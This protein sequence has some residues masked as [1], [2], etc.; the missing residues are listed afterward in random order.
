MANCS[1]THESQPSSA[2]EDALARYQQKIS[3]DFQCDFGGVDD[4]TEG[5]FPSLQN[6]E[7]LDKDESLDSIGRKS[8]EDLFNELCAEHENDWITEM[9]E[10]GTRTSEEPT[11]EQ[12]TAVEASKESK[13]DKNE[14]KMDT[15]GSPQSPWGEPA[16][17]PV[18]AWSNS[19]TSAS[20]AKTDN[21][22]SGD[23]WANFEDA[24]FGQP[25]RSSSP[26]SGKNSEKMETD[27]FSTP[28]NNTEDHSG[29][30]DTSKPSNPAE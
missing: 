27:T 13:D 8:K 12:P 24:D 15:S 28:A 4:D 23:G 5:D 25:D 16:G 19:S 3:P 26:E 9:E 21:Q 7:I 18:L 30:G 29:N 10:E 6:D 22:T 2:A 20:N 17:D 14:E 1:I 11:S